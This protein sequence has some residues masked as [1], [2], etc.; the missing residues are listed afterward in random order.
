MT[1]AT[2]TAFQWSLVGKDFTLPNGNE[3]I[4]FAKFGIVYNVSSHVLKFSWDPKTLS[5]ANKNEKMRLQY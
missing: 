1:F 3:K 4:P 5:L 2:F